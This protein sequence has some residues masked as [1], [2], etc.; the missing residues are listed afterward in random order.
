MKVNVLYMEYDL[1]LTDALFEFMNPY[2][3]L[4]K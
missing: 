4:A 3:D 1:N 2:S